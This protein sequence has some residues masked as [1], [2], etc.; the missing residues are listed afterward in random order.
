VTT[1]DTTRTSTTCGT[2]N[3]TVPV[4]PT[5]QSCHTMLTSNA[6][7]ESVL[8]ATVRLSDGFELVFTI[9]DPDLAARFAAQMI[10]GSVRLHAAQKIDAS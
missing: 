6:D 10:D 1:L 3:R 5:V 4:L 9:T 7:G 8:S 2:S